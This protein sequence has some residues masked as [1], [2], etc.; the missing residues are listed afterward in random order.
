MIDGESYIESEYL[1]EREFNT[2]NRKRFYA[3]PDADGSLSN[4]EREKGIRLSSLVAPSAPQIDVS[5]SAGYQRIPAQDLWALTDRKCFSGQQLKASKR[6]GEKPVEFWPRPSFKPAF[7]FVVAELSTH[8]RDIRLLSYARQTRSPTFYWPLPIFLD[9]R[10]CVLEGVNRYQQQQ[11]K[12]TFLQQAAILGTLHVPTGARYLLLTPLAEA[13]DLPN[14]QLSDQ[15][16]LRLVS[17]QQ[18]TSP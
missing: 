9:E 6:L 15:G 14:I 12:A 13:V 18:P 2:D 1:E 7:D 4:V 11:L 3:I 10:G 16:Q 17:L 8:V 5:L